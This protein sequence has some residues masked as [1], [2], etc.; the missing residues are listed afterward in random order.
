MT[1]CTCSVWISFSLLGSDFLLQEGAVSRWSKSAASLHAS[2]ATALGTQ[3][4]LK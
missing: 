4:R 2:T 1:Y 3:I